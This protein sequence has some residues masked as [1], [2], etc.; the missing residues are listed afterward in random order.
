MTWPMGPLGEESLPS[1]LYRAAPVEQ[2]LTVANYNADYQYD[3]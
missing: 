3:T 1:A 2:Y